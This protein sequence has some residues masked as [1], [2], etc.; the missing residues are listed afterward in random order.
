MKVTKI[1]Y[2]LTFRVE[3][4]LKE[5]TIP[6]VSGQTLHLGRYAIPFS[7]EDGNRIFDS[8]PKD[9]KE[10]ILTAIECDYFDEKNRI[11]NAWVQTG[12]QEKNNK[13]KAQNGYIYLIKNQNAYKIGRAKKVQERFNKYITEN[14]H[15][16]SL[17]LSY[18]VADYIKVEANL[19]KRF[20]HKKIRGEWFDL[21]KSDIKEIELYL[22]SS[23]I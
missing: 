4:D 17:I 14:P 2:Q 9:I 7:I 16:I 6:C 5:K 13:R 12:Q 15:S 18:K 21:I 10:N 19:L 22:K 3:T 1:E 11:Q 8:L 23:T 20:E